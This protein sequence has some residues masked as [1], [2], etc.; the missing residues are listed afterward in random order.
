MCNASPRYQAAGEIISPRINKKSGL[1]FCV[2]HMKPTISD[3]AE[4][5][6]LA[7][8]T[9]PPIRSVPG[10]RSE[11]KPA[12]NPNKSHDTA[13]TIRNSVLMEGFD[14]GMARNHSNS[15]RHENSATN[16]HASR[17][18][19][20]SISLQN[21]EIIH[22]EATSCFA[23][24]LSSR[25]AL[26]FRRMLPCDLCAFLWQKFGKFPPLLALSALMHSLPHHDLINHATGTGV[27]FAFG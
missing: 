5:I 13:K 27:F 25:R 19:K 12:P 7:P 3:S 14:D 10:V 23:I 26:P 17:I 18:A 24:L 1:T 6:K 20:S 21:L 16:A 4:T 22:M 9:R 2:K 11:I 8:I 15:E